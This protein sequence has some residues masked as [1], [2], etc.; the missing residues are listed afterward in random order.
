MARGAVPKAR[1]PASLIRFLD[2]ARPAVTQYGAAPGWLATSL[3]DELSWYVAAPDPNGTAGR[4]VSCAAAG[5]VRKIAAEILG[6][7]DVDRA[8]PF[9]PPAVTPLS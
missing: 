8:P 2:L 5:H 6:L 9:V 3:L 4:P 1:P 7:V